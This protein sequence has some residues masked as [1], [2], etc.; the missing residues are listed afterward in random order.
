MINKNGKILWA[1]TF[2]LSNN[3]FD[4]IKQ[5]DKEQLAHANDHLQSNSGNKT[6]IFWVKFETPK[7]HLRWNSTP[8]KS[9]SN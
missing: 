9:N 7:T 8:E 4:A 2:L 3:L 5:R 1:Y 6:K